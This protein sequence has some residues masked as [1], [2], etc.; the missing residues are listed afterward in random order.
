[1]AIQRFKEQL[2][3]QLQSR[4]KQVLDR[5][6]EFDEDTSLGHKPEPQK[7]WLREV[8]SELSRYRD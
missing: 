4:M 1:M 7:R 8:Q 3:D 6:R 5:N 2:E